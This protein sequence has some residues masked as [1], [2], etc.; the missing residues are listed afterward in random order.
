M[1]HFSDGIKIDTS[2]SYRTVR[3]PD[4]WYV[5]GH[6]MLLPVEDRDEGNQII[7]SMLASPAGE[8]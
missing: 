4:G 7:R 5:V 3:Y 2:G 6:G 8:A 1:L